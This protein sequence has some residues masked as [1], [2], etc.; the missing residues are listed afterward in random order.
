MTTPTTGAEELPDPSPDRLRA[1]ART[2]RNSSGSASDDCGPLAYVLHGW[3]AAAIAFRAQQAAQVEAL[4]AAQAGVPAEAVGWIDDGGMLFWKGDPL[5]DGSDIY[6]AP[7]PSPSPAPATSL[8]EAFASARAALLQCPD[9]GSVRAI[10]D[11]LRARVDASSQYP[12]PAR[13][14]PEMV[15]SL[16]QAVDT[17]SDTKQRL[18]ALSARLREIDASPAPAQPGQE[19]ERIPA[20]YGG[21]PAPDSGLGGALVK[22][23]WVAGTL[24]QIKQKYLRGETIDREWNTQA[25][26][27]CSAVCFVAK[28]IAAVEADRAAR[29]APQPATDYDHGPQATTIEEAARDVGKWLNERPSRPI[30][31]R[32]VAMLTHYA[33]APQPAM[34]DAKR[35]GA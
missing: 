2:A 13:V 11:V 16:E 1:I 33:Q 8:D 18:D 32:H 14:T 31:L 12:A 27:M 19:G 10:I 30:D 17:L 20:D 4:S 34:A 6:A 7:Q 15:E 21:T 24:W 25:V 3:R 26:G 29:A 5:P 22:L 35:G 28:Q 23:E 9:R